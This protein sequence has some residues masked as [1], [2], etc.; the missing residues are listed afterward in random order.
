MSLS[1]SSHEIEI[2]I[3]GN[4]FGEC[5]V[6]HVG[7]GEWIIVDSFKDPYSKE[8][9]A[10]E[11]LKKINVDYSKAVQAIVA[12]HWHDDHICGLSQIVKECKNALFICS[13]AI[14]KKDFLEFVCSDADLI[15]S[16]PGIKELR[17]IL[18]ELRGRNAKITLALENRV[19][20][21]NPQYQI[22]SLSPSDDAVLLAL[23]E[24]AGF[25]PKEMQPRKGIPDIHPN[26][27]GIVLL[28]CV[29]G[30]SILLGADLEEPINGKLGWS[31]IISS[32]GR[33][34]GKS[35]AFKIPHHGSSTAHHDGIWVHL[36][37][38]KPPSFLS[39]FI[40]GKCLLPQKGDIKRI[41][42]YTDKVWITTSPYV[43]KKAN[44]RDRM[45]EKTIKETVKSIRSL[46]DKGHIRMRFKGSNSW[47][48]ELFGSAMPLTECLTTS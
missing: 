26:Y 9:I 21:N 23:Q 46:S 7:N 41:L 6:V 14:K 10:L 17:N 11:Y 13:D 32:P 4:G 43:K 1:P 16:R 5:V 28:I 27:T 15:E 3:F 48:V 34:T 25:L 44:K 20:L 30:Q 35:N 2:S 39:S 45:V 47:N 29:D 42:E 8:P 38:P 37:E 12:T 31:A 36:L 24:I 18:E 33:P 40:R 19:L 22:H